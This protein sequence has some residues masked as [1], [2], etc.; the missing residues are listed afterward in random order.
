ML[1][2]KRQIAEEAQLKSQ[3]PPATE[4]F[5]TLLLRYGLAVVLFLTIHGITLLLEYFQIKVNLTIL[6]LI[7]LAA[8]SWYG[9]K[10]PGITLSV[11]VMGM[12]FIRTPL[13]PESTFAKALFGYFSVFSLLVFI[14]WLI[15]GRKIV[16]ERLLNSEARYRHLFEN[17]PLPMWV[18]DLET[19]RFLAVNDAATFYYGYSAKEFLA[20]TI[21]DIRPAETVPA[22]LNNI[23]KTNST[24]DDADIWQHR[25]KNSELI[26]VEITSHELVFDGK[27]ARL[28]S[29][30]DVTKRKQSEKEL[31]NLAAIVESSSDAI[32]SA[33][34]QDIIISWNK[35]AEKI[36]GYSTAEAIGRNLS[37]LY[38]SSESTKEF[39]PAAKAKQGKYIQQLETT[40][41]RKDGT[42]LPV[43]LTVSPIKNAAGEVVA[44]S[45]IIHD[46]TQRKRTNTA[47]RE[48]EYKF[49]TLLESMSE[50]LLQVDGEDCIQFVNNCLCEMVGYA[51]DELIG[52]DWSFLLLD[53]ERD[54]IK[55]INERRSKGI[56]DR[57]E[58]R[59]RKKSGE[60]LWVIVGGA[61]LINVEGLVV[62]SMGTFT[63]ITE[64]KRAEEQLLHDAFHDN[65]TGLA[66]RTLFMDH[67]RLT[68]ERHKRRPEAAFAVLFLDF[69]RFK[70]INDSLG[71]QEGD[72]LLIQIAERLTSAL[73]P[74]DLVA[75]LGGD[76]F[77]VLLSEIDHESEALIITE[78]LQE[79]LK[80]PFDLS[81]RE[82][83]SSASIGLA[84]STSGHNSAE[85]MLRDADI[86]MYRAKSK[87]KAQYQ[88][89]DQAM[90]K[91]TLKQ[92]QLETEM[93]YALERDEF[94]LH[95]QPIIK[96]DSNMLTGFEALVRWN[97]PDRGIISP[98]EFIPLAEET[99]LILPLGDWIL[100]SG[101]RQLREW[102]A[103]GAIH[104]E[105]V[106]SVNLSCK[107][108][109]QF[110]LA[111]RIAATL[112]E[113]GLAPSCLKLEIT[114]SY[115]LENTATAIEIMHRLRALGVE[116]SLDDFGT[117]YSS[118]SY[119]HSLPI[120]YLK[121]DRSFVSRLLDS[122]ENAE[123]VHTIIKL[124]QNLKM[125]VVAEG[126][127]TAEQLATL[128]QLKCEYGQGYFFSKPLKASSAIN[129]NR[130]A[131]LD[132]VV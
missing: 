77:T 130:Y 35:G 125:Q 38:S 62:G 104:P 90:R 52:R 83:F 30:T 22:L 60:I 29:A 101:C 86:A 13:P 109:L 26:D 57:Y 126:I 9:G 14:V 132:A 70:I 8:V 15:S 66:N 110:D 42:D 54:L 7:I 111:E 28:V 18:Y 67:L 124:A 68:I 50:G 3:A 21:K 112:K 56:S 75:R 20:M 120:D 103:Q 51:E 95:Y 122:P 84:L 88:V 65:L 94:C 64:R 72:K 79:K 27:A 93:R 41:C 1:N 32:V 105:A 37:I 36:F 115:I 39:A 34:L 107:Q 11:L 116:L 59:L 55:E 4:S 46:V 5:R 78:R 99:G 118:L 92:L 89:F 16:S 129:F 74:G 128:Q 87:G 53:E 63:D 96:L 43:S 31:S 97:H 80:A 100:R 25:K 76:E 81:G 45:A 106:I 102:Q 82:V 108:F 48:S 33:D 131:V 85:D 58:I 117:G 2:I 24:I 121:I 19:L 12:L 123:I 69:D 127:E 71:H 40:L 23:L 49:R 47:L 6:L 119:L 10:G 61:P 44:V 114:E 73:R 113:T 91:S 98:L 17:N